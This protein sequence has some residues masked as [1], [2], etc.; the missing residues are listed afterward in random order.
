MKNVNLLER[1]ERKI[2]LIRT[3]KVMLDSDLARLYKVPGKQLNQQ[4]KRNIT[5]FPADFMFQITTEE[6]DSLRSHFVTL[7]VFSG[8]SR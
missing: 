4:V 7:D 1:I 8:P 5:R 6:Y 3:Q 2:F